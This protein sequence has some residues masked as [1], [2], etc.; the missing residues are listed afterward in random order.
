[1]KQKSKKLF[2]NEIKIN[3]DELEIK[4]EKLK[5][6]TAILLKE[7]EQLQKIIALIVIKELIRIQS[8]V[9]IVIINI[10]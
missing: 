4:I 8:D 10:L 7:K 1:M 6:V 3:D 5:I 2:S 9:M